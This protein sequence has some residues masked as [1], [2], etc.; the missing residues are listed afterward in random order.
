F[1][2]VVGP[3]KPI[4]GV[5]R[6]KATGRPLAGVQVIGTEPATWTQALTWTDAQGRFRLIGLPKGRTYEVDTAPRPGVDPFLG[7]KVRVSDTEGL[8]PI[9]TA[10]E[11]PR[12]IIITGRLVDRV[13][14]RPVRAKHVHYQTLPTNRNEGDIPVTSSGIIDPTFRLTVP[15]GGGM[16]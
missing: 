4:T 3:T 12:G 2:H 8:K 10:L 14:G 1:E 9:E 5:V 11:L 16:L 15:P 7:I 6:L 13:A